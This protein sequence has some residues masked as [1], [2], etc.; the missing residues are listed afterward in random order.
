MGFVLYDLD[1]DL[2]SIKVGL[3][4]YKGDF[5]IVEKF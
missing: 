2:R 4:E 1:R 3:K 5:L